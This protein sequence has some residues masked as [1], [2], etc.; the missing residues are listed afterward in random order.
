MVVGNVLKRVRDA[1]D[2]VLLMNLRHVD[3]RR[4]DLTQRKILALR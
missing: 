1:R 4:A 3:A 2:Q